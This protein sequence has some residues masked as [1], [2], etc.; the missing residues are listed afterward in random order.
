MNALQILA[1][2]A[3]DAIDQADD[4][5]S[6]EDA[7]LVYAIAAGLQAFVPTLLYTLIAYTNPVYRT[8]TNFLT[9]V[10]AG[11]WWP[12]F[13]AWVGTQFFD[14][15]Q[16]REIFKYA[17]TISL[18]GPFALYWTVITDMLIVATDTNNWVSWLWWVL[19]GTAVL[20]T[21]LSIVF[22]VIFVPKVYSWV[23]NAATVES[24]LE[25][26]DA[27]DEEDDGVEVTVTVD[28]E[29]LFSL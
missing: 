13:I 7:I 26:V 27:V 4:Q 18:A 16:I 12:S 3:A 19:F 17:V 14:S 1:D 11:I 29:E 23:E 6:D 24:V 25:D 9:K 15:D 10:F 5:F 28:G 2:S 22:Q 20:Y 21:I 8:T